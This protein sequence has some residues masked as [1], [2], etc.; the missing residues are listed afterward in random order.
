MNSRSIKVPADRVRTREQIL[1]DVHVTQ[2]S[3]GNEFV[4]VTCHNCGGTGRYP[5]SMIPAGQCRFYCWNNRTPETFGKLPILADKYVKAQQ[6]ADRRAYREPIMRAHRKAEVQ[7]RSQQADPRIVKL[8]GSYGWDLANLPV[9]GSQLGDA[10]KPKYIAR[11]IIDHY[12]QTGELSVDQWELVT[13]KLPS[14]QADLDEKARRIEE[15]KA[16]SKHVGEIKERIRD[17]AAKLVY[18]RELEEGMYGRRFLYVFRTAEDDRLTWFSGAT[19]TGMDADKLPQDVTI[20]FTVKK[21]DEYRGEKN[22]V[23]TRAKVELAR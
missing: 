23:V 12:L 10:A 20:S 6:A 13:T 22:T 17:M 16:N 7:K 19:I 18:F 21:H 4:W 2:D 1:A 9:S 8:A 11:D 5:S 14:W 3:N 15:Q